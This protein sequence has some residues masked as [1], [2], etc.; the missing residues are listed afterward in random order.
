[1]DVNNLT[2]DEQQ[3]LSYL[4]NKANGGE[5][6]RGVAPPVPEDRKFGEAPP[7]NPATVTRVIPPEEWVSKQINTM[8][9]VGE[10][11]YRAGITRPKKNPIEAGIAAQDKYEAKMRDPNVLKR[12]VEKLRKTNM[13]EWAAMAE[14]VGAGRLVSG[15]VER[16]FK[17]ERFVGGYQ[18]KLMGHLRSIDAMPDVTDAD[19]ERRMIENLK[20]LKKL[21]GTV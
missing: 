8:S 2:P 17:V 14:R 16:R 13:D 3:A 5:S 15:V 9:A 12:R 11:N 21:K 19:R 6:S 7:P 20:G 18:P 1:M 10:T 4:V